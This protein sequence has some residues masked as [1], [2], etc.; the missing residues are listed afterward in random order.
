MT[1]VRVTVPGLEH[2]SGVR[3]GLD[4]SLKKALTTPRSDDLDLPKG[5][6]RLE[7]SPPGPGVNVS[8][9]SGQVPWHQKC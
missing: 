5:T 6:N 7:E 9:Q 1:F 8:W 3:N 2:W 4:N